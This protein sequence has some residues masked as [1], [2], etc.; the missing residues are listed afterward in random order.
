MGGGL[1]NND[2][3]DLLV[4]NNADLLVGT[5]FLGRGIYSFVKVY[6][7][8]MYEAC[9]SIKISLAF[10]T[11]NFCD[12]ILEKEQR[13]FSFFCMSGLRF[14]S[15]FLARQWRSCSAEQAPACHLLCASTNFFFFLQFFM[16]QLDSLL[17][18]T[19]FLEWQEC[20]GTSCPEFGWLKCSAHC[21]KNFFLMPGYQKGY[22]MFQGFKFVEGKWNE[23]H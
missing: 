10:I 6:I 1:L 15:I 19:G 17:T 23:A 16:L 20:S 21:W 9:W 4:G 11:V 2:N 14:L 7:R 22:R 13:L 18:T 5:C 12:N 3:V 8:C